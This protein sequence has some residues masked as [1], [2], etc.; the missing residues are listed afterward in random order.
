MPLLYYLE[1]GEAGKD[2]I[3]DR[4]LHTTKSDSQE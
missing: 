4:F 2:S 1:H 3:T